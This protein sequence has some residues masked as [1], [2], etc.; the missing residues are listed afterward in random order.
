[1]NAAIKGKDILAVMP[2]GAG[3]SLCFQFPALYHSGLTLVICP[4]IALMRDQVHSLQ[5]LGLKAASISSA[6]NEKDNEATIVA[7]IAGQLKL[8]YIAP[9]KL[10]SSRFNSIIKKLN[11]KTIAVDEAHCIS[12]WGHDFRPDYLRIGSFR[13][14]LGNVQIIALTATASEKTRNEIIFSLFDKKPNV[15]CYD[16]DRPNIRLTCVLKNKP[17]SQLLKFIRS[18]GAVS[19]IVYCKTRSK[20]EVLCKALKYEGLNAIFY[21]GGMDDNERRK[22]EDSFQS[23]QNLIVCATVA[24]GMGIDK[25]NIKFV[26]H[27]D[28]PQ[29]IEEYY[30]EIGRAGRNGRPAEAFL[31]YGMEDVKLRRMY[32]DESDND[33]NRKSY[34][35]SKL[36]ALLGFADSITCRRSK[37][38]EYFSGIKITNCKN[39]D[40]CICPPEVFDAS[41]EIEMALGA[42]RETGESFGQGYLIKILRG[43]LSENIVERKHENLESFGEGNHH[44]QRKWQ[45]IFLQMAGLDLISFNS[46][47]IGLVSLTD[48]AWKF[49]ASDAKIELNAHRFVTKFIHETMLPVS[50]FSEDDDNLF[51]ALRVKRKELA[52]CINVPAYFI[53]TD[54]ILIEIVKKKP[55][56]LFELATISGIGKKKLSQYGKVF[57][58]ILHANDLV[59]G[60][61][62]R[63]KIFGKVNVN[64]YEKLL[65]E[66]NRNSRGRIGL[67]KPLHVS[68]ALLAR[69]VKKSPKN[70]ME[71]DNIKGMNKKLVDR[72]GESFLAVINEKD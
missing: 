2:T 47:K 1:M 42:I 8:L 12:K 11:I 6:N 29:S 7:A 54:N 56:D 28:L 30:Q 26:A 4:L 35:H 10:A 31:L 18:Q 46:A 9:E 17:R 24:F 52:K 43:E 38:L 72:F 53:L 39:C 34:N 59:V 66:T 27:A 68:S 49:L 21:H 58:D 20:A 32:I 45:I 69:I 22:A 62:A 60:H 37:L 13:K 51:N 65:A 44:S 70:L 55:A 15:F 23:E 5:K 16:I 50:L 48:K 19:G 67:D 57:L 40:V 61:L 3:K 71:L 33:L 64:L 41:K 36:N 14:R 63:K 25:A